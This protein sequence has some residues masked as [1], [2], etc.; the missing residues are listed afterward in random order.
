ML[1]LRR[2][3]VERIFRL[4]LPRESFLNEYHRRF[5]TCYF[6][7]WFLRGDAILSV[8]TVEVGRSFDS[9]PQFSSILMIS[10]SLV[11]TFSLRPLVSFY[12]L[13]VV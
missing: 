6:L 2:S 5:V 10:C 11:D 8:A 4:L 1:Y 3:T 7:L 12:E 9:L 13:D